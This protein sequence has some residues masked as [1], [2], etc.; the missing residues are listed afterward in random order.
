[1]IGQAVGVLKG[2]PGAANKAAAFR[3]MAV[4]IARANSGW[5]ATLVRGVDGAYIFA[6]K[7]GEAL[8]IGPN[9]ALFRGN[10]TNWAA[11]GSAIGEA[12]FVVGVGGVFSPV[13]EALR[14]L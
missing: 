8:V 6:G 4:Q 12:Q 1:M 14:G 2:I 10:I 9:G 11:Q 13:Y 5:S 7:A 3:A